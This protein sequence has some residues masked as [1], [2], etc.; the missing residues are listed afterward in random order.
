MARFLP[1]YISSREQFKFD[2]PQ[3]AAEAF[4][5]CKL[6]GY[7]DLLASFPVLGV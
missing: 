4:A 5:V 7:I 3:V 1:Y 6:E 2:L